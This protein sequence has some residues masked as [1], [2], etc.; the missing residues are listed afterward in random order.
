M[1]QIA[2]GSLPPEVFQNIICRLDL[3]DI[4]SLRLTASSL[5]DSA[6]RNFQIHLFTKSVDVDSRNELDEFTRMSEPGQMGCFMRSLTLKIVLPPKGNK[7]PR[8][9]S[10]G[11]AQVL[12]SAL[13]NLRLNTASGRLQTLTL[14]VE[15]EDISAKVYPWSYGQV[16]GFD[17]WKPVWDAAQRV[18]LIA[19][20]ALE[21][22]GL[23]IDEF[24]V[25]GSIRRCS[26]A[27]DLL[28]P[29]LRIDFSASF[30]GLKRL[31]LS[32]SD[33]MQ[34]TTDPVGSSARHVESVCCFIQLCPDLEVLELHWFH[35]FHESE[36]EKA[37]SE[38]ERRFFNSLADSVTLTSL[39]RLS[40]RGVRAT[41]A[42]LTTFFAAH[43]LLTELVM[44][45]V[46]LDS[47]KFDNV[48]RT[49]TPRLEY[50]HLDNLW[51]EK[52][53]Y[54]D[55]K[56]TPHVPRSCR[57]KKKIGPNDLTREGNEAKRPIRCKQSNGRTLG[58]PQLLRWIGQRRAQYGPP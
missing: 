10:K 2:L 24:D 32:L 19:F 58:S 6:T 44:E 47:G 37:G 53:L 42:A 3:G 22:S 1:A 31:S 41:E 54:F 51:A 21:I 28:A 34:K 46:A 36:D 7:K 38:Q 57:D 23:P 35:L 55:I 14:V 25:F 29:V 45:D 5:K 27:C 18:L 9:K 30:R 52:L 11:N 8:T 26:L 48:F 15:R 49:I 12:A 43:P 39:R 40:L 17:N 56:G 33:H 16:Q 20:K 13:N 4:R 50:I